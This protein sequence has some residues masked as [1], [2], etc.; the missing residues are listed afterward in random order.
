LPKLRGARAAAKTK[1]PKSN[2]EFFLEKMHPP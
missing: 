1:T 2:P